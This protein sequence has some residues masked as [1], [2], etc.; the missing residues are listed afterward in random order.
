VSRFSLLSL[1]K[2][3]RDWKQIV[4]LTD[5]R[6]DADHVCLR[7]CVCGHSAADKVCRARTYIY[8][9]SR[10]EPSRKESVKAIDTLQRYSN[11][12]PPCPSI[13]CFK[14]NQQQMPKSPSKYSTADIP[15]GEMCRV[16]TCWC[17]R[18]LFSPP[19]HCLHAV[20]GPC[21]Y[22]WILFCIEQIKRDV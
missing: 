1:L 3:T 15:I 18:P 14:D 7:C 13:K 4:I 9:T 2:W 22:F 20:L 10:A 16:F 5:R 11:F 8:R 6:G 12:S 17:T 19:S 21:I